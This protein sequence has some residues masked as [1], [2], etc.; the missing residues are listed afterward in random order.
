MGEYAMFVQV[1]TVHD[2]VEHMFI[3]THYTCMEYS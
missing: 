3:A 2:M 1:S